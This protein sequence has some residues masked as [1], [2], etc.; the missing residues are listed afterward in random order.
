ML[1]PESSINL[2]EKSFSSPNL[3]KENEFFK[4]SIEEINDF[5]IDSSTKF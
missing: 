4:K 3:R 1:N 5:S 2:K